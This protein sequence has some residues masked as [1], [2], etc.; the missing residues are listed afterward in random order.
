[1]VLACR[2][3]ERVVSV[4]STA[5]VLHAAL[6]VMRAQDALGLAPI[7][8]ISLDAA[9]APLLLDEFHNTMQ[10]HLIDI[11]II[12]HCTT[13]TVASLNTPYLYQVYNS[14][15]TFLNTG[16]LLHPQESL[17]RLKST[18]R[19]QAAFTVEIDCHNVAMLHGCG[20]TDQVAFVQS[21]CY[22]II[23]SDLDEN[24]SGHGC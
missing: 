18:G 22:K 13:H 5:S 4:C 14:M 12:A 8:R 1:V 23:F 2:L 7:F 16:V 6:L 3:L 11:T 17:S 20:Q 24:R 19:L 21:P 10:Q 9:D 15:V